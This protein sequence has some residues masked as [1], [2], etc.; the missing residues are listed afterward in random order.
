M[1]IFTSN[2]FFLLVII[3]QAFAFQTQD[4]K[5][6]KWVDSVL[7]QMTINEKIGQLF[8]IAAYS[9]QGEKHEQFIEEQIKKYHIGGLIFFQGTPERQ[10]QLT[11][12]YQ[13]ISKHPLLIGLDAEHGAGWRLKSAMEFPKMGIIGA[14]QN[15]SLVYEL[16]AAIAR[17]CH[18]LGVH[19]NFAPV[20]D[21]NNNP[22]NPVIGIRA[23]GENPEEVAQKAISYMKGSLS[24]QVLPV[25]KHFP[26]HGD[27][28]QDSHHTL[29]IISHNRHRLDSLELYPYRKLIEANVPAI[30]ISHLNV[31]ALDE[32]GV[33]SSL[34]PLI[35]QKLLKEELHFSGLCITDAMNMKGVTN[36]SAPGEAEVKALLAGNDI[37][38]FPADISKAIEAIKKAIT[39]RKLTPE[40]LHEK[41]RKIL[42]AKYLYALPNLYPSQAPGLWSRL[43][44]PQDFTLKR[45][46]YKAALT[47]VSNSDSL[48]PLKRLDT[49]KIASV[50]FGKETINNF[51]TSLD[52]YAEIKHF[53]LKKEISSEEL[54][55]WLPKLKNYNCIIIYN[56][57]AN[58]SSSK[59]FGYTPRLSQLLDS[60][61]GKRVI[62]CHPAT[63]YGLQHYITK[64]VDA[65]LISY[66]N[67]LHAQEFAAQSIFGGVAIKGL[68]PVSI[69]PDYPVGIGIQ[70]SKTR[71]GYD[72]PESCQISSKNLSKI[73][74]LCQVAIQQQA[75]PGCQVLIAK[76][77]T[78][79]YN[80]TFGH[81]TYQKKRPNKI[82]DIYD[83][84]SV[85]KITAT[86][87]AIMLLYD[88]H[89]IQLEQPL[90]N[91]YT[92]LKET[93]K[94]EIT[95]SEVLCHHAG[96]KSF[97][98]FLSDAID[99]NSI[100]GPLFSSKKTAHNTLWLK[101]RLY[102]NVNYKFKDNT[103][104]NIKRPD[105]KQVA[106]GLY[107]HH[108]YQDSILYHILH[109]PLENKKKYCYSDLG[110]ILLKYAIE[111]I[112]GQNFSLFCKQ[113]FF[114]RLG[115]YSTDFRANERLSK[116]RIVPS[117]H[118]KLYRKTVVEGYVHDPT[119]ALLGGIAGHAGLFSTAEDL[120]KMLQ[121]YLN[122]G[123]YGG[124][125]F[126]SPAT[127]EKF[128]C[129]NTIFP[130]NRRGF[131]FD[132]P[133]PDT[134]KSSPVCKE[135]PLCSYGHTGFTGII[136]WCDPKNDLIYIFMSNRT[137]P[138]EFD[139]KLSKLN[140]RTQIQEVI[141]EC[142]K[143]SESL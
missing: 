10:I 100:P 75:T 64:P 115:M 60:L 74:S 43:N 53:T 25:A 124:E 73:D 97:I 92:A 107:I 127:V 67:H 2:L 59:K 42:L 139:S 6:E 134:T 31:P 114:R 135:A 32:S 91:Y 57:V 52:H 40:M 56:H 77:G 121:M 44:S 24:K 137:Y 95:V 66:E 17:H 83:I 118:D 87:P 28:D 116:S 16:G 68:L 76:N 7:T 48:L 15:D 45:E 71:L 69:N 79:I 70:T 110:F 39:N 113:T 126:F 132:K 120:A 119:A 89:E 81:H 20:I 131:G 90:A 72:E 104:S 96:L 19:V 117:S 93:D 51:Q 141:Y 123:S 82:N 41:C 36:H 29:P 13:K 34:S 86:L 30:M 125:Y 26:G 27:T 63:P 8:M 58:N 128:T 18:T 84:A 62:L 133:E 105:Y 130:Q 109:S 122:K 99:K 143:Q 14:I 37:L 88:K 136:A 94:K 9:N 108:S 22:K 103:F 47:L 138:N 106:T 50:N 54:Q 112:S 4:E 142:I 11:W 46:L 98:P 38:L 80:K 21:I 61:T 101:H 65:I 78:I 102:A 129:A 5:A 85:T 12:R 55:T 23:F 1:K 35:V 140:I 3:S 49:L 111:E 33:P